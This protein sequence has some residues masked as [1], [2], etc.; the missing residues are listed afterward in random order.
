VFHPRKEVLV[1][2]RSKNAS[3]QQQQPEDLPEAIEV[4]EV[5]EVEDLGTA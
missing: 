1:L 2:G 4:E 3:K 5:E